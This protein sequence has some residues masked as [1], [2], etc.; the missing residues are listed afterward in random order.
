MQFGG[1]NLGRAAVPTKIA[2]EDC[3]ANRVSQIARHGKRVAAAGSRLNVVAAI[4]TSQ[5]A[6]V[7][8]GTLF[9][10]NDPVSALT[11]AETVAL[12][13]CPGDASF[14]KA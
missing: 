3:G 10:I 2:K 14:W 8:C 5:N 4:L 6:S 13:N 1:G 11:T 12:R 7:T 9:F